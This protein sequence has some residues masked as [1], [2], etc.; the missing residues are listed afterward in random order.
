V[1]ISTEY[2]QICVKNNCEISTSSQALNISG[3]DGIYEMTELIFARVYLL[4][5]V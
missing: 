4:Q 1:Y 2:H 5:F 3:K